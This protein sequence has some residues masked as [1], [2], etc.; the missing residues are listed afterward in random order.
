MH[1]Q[2]DG[3]LDHP[4]GR[5]YLQTLE[6]DDVDYPVQKSCDPAF[7]R[8]VVHCLYNY[9]TGNNKRSAFQACFKERWF[10]FTRTSKIRENMKDMMIVI[11]EDKLA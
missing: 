10:F 5:L 1:V 11:Q 7:N 4:A 2:P 3:I 8:P 6:G 9:T